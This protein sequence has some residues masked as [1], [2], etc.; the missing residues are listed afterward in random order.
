VVVVV[1]ARC[2]APAA[3]RLD[4]TAAD[5]PARWLGRRV[6]DPAQQTRSACSGT[7]KPA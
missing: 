4:F 1:R 7:R 6:T 3:T 5:D 2:C